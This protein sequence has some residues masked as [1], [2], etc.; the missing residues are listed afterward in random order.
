MAENL[1]R[2]RS[3]LVGV[4]VAL[5]SI[6]G[7]A[8]AAD[9]ITGDDIKNDT[10]E[11]KDV[12]DETLRT[13]DLSEEAQ[14]DL[15]GRRGPEGDQGDPGPPGPPGQAAEYA[16]PEWGLIARNT[17]GSPEA[18]LRGGPI[19]APGNTANTQPPFGDGS[20]GLSV[21]ADPDGIEKVAFG[22]E[23]D[24]VGDDVNDI[25]ELGFHVFTTLE[26]A[27]RGEPMPKIDIEIDP[28]LE[29]TSSGFSTLVWV[30]PDPEPGDIN[31]WSGYIDAT[32]E[33]EFFLTGAA[34]TATN[35]NQANPCTFDEVQTALEDGGDE[36]KVFTVAAGKGRDTNFVGAVDGL[37]YNENA[38]DF[39]PFGVNEV[40]NPTPGS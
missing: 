9:K 37:Q 36:A 40:S 13:R 8:Y 32:S 10:I 2:F 16:N 39:E 17:I 3:V 27:D 4:G 15:Q 23:V 5:V 28:N 18:E 25:T 1:R 11:S 19:V 33:G 6:V 30:P 7:V 26:N 21:A 34:G 24:F 22:N 14:D 38:Y 31:R 29:S 12:K 35:C 20:L